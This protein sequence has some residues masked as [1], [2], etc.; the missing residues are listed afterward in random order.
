MNKEPKHFYESG[1]CRVN[2]EK[3]LYFAKT[4]PFPCNRRLS[5]SLLV[6]VEHTETVILKE[7]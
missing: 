7:S 1:R 4:G 5:Y 2:P 3:R 6:L